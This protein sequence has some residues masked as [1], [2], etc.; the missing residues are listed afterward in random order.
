MYFNVGLKTLYQ[1][2]GQEI[3]G[4]PAIATHKGQL[5]WW[6]LGPVYWIIA[7][8]VAMSVPQFSAF[9]NFVGALFSLNFTY[10]IPGIMFIALKI[11]Q[12]AAQEGEGYD[13]ATGRTTR[14]DQ[15]LKRW[16]RGFLNGWKYTVPATLYSLAGLASSGM[17]TWA[18]VLALEAAFGPDGTVLTSWTCTNP[19]SPQAQAAA[20]SAAVAAATPTA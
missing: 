4:L 11:Q 2:V 17:G 16:I 13:P 3:F 5:V 1:E 15:G 7:F 20:L 12:S 18:A 6:A 9:T 14:H 8:V 19:F 10:S